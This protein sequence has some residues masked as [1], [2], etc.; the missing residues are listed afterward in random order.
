MTG[1]IE[2][3]EQIK[4]FYIKNEVFIVPVLKFLM[5]LVTLTVINNNIGYMPKLTNMALVAMFALICSFL[6]INAILLFAA[7][8][9]IGHFYAV[10]LPVALVALA[11]FV[12]MFLLYYRLAPKEAYYVVLVPIAFVLKIPYAVP[13]AAGLLGTPFSAVPVSFGVIM[14]Y[15]M[16]TVKQ[17]ISIMSNSEASNML[18]T[19]T[20]LIDSLINNKGMLLMVMAFLVT[21]IVV[22]VI[23]RQSIDYSW[24]IAIA[25]GA[26]TNMLILLFGDYMLNITASFFTLLLGNVVSVLI[27][28]IIQFMAF[29]VDYTRT[30]H[31]QFEDDEYYYYVKAVP[32]VSIT[33]KDK[34]IKRINTQKKTKRTSLSRTE[35]IDLENELKILK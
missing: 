34:K 4:S 14:Y 29:D 3:R 1:L 17:N 15:L 23:R 6:P 12:I 19:Y 26:V 7:I 28:L 32:K 25:I 8:F 20:Y 18:Q 16:E 11:L 35:E 31:V 30:E 5:A 21:T 27:G 9:I 22:Y 2:F 33:S 24:S 13:I 10:S